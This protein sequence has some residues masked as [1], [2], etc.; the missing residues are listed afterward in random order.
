M[1]KQHYHKNVVN[2][3]SYKES[4]L[5][6]GTIRAMVMTINMIIIETKQHKT[7]W[8]YERYALMQ[9]QNAKVQRTHLETVWTEYLQYRSVRLCK[10]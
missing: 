3:D 7:F 5:N 9:I 6:R 4:I 10:L 8:M 2:H 1:W